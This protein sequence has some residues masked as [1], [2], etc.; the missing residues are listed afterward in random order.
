MQFCVLTNGQAAVQCG[1]GHTIMEPS[2]NDRRRTSPHL[3]L[4]AATRVPV[5]E[6]MW[7]RT[8]WKPS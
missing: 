5:L 2:G 7:G 6:G 1:L 4:S 3:C 8:A